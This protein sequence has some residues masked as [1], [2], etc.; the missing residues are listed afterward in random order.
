VGSLTKSRPRFRTGDWVSFLY[1]TRRLLVQVIEDR[2][3]IGVRGRR[4][5]GVRLDNH[6]EEPATSEIPEDDLEPAP[7]IA[8]AQ[9]ARERGFSAQNWP[10]QGFEVKYVRQGKTNKWVAT[11][12]PGEQFRGVTTKGAVGYSTARWESET[13]A[14]ENHAFVFVLIEVDPR[15]LD[16]RTKVDPALRRAVAEEARELADQ[17]FKSRHPEAVIE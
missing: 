5:Y 12:E 3:P 10:R 17:M 15:L 7:E 9:V 11:A 6:L 8:P 13:E 1:G 4:L 16:P 14:D 2:G